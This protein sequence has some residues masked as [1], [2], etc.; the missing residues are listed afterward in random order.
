[1]NQKRKERLGFGLSP[2]SKLFRWFLFPPTPTLGRK[3][4]KRDWIPPGLSRLDSIPNPSQVLYN[5]GRGE[6][7]GGWAVEWLRTTEYTLVP[8]DKIEM[9]ASDLSSLTQGRELSCLPDNR[10]T[11]RRE[12]KTRLLLPMT[13]EIKLYLISFL[14]VYLTEMINLSKQYFNILPTYIQV[15]LLVCRN[16]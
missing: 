9:V 6:W 3:G 11:P 4:V 15:Y 10:L 7:G 14:S 16:I 5:F 13:G 8:S 2:D 12:M 1:M